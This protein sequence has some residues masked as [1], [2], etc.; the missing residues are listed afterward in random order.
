MWLSLDGRSERPTRASRR[1]TPQG[2][3]QSRR[4]RAHLV[5]GS[6]KAP[7]R[8][9]AMFLG[10]VPLPILSRLRSTPQSLW[11]PFSSQP[12]WCPRPDTALPSR[13]F[14]RHRP[15]P[16]I[17]PLHRHLHASVSADD[18]SAS[19]RSR[20]PER[21]RFAPSP[22]GHLHVGG[23]RTALFNW[24]FARH[25]GGKFI[26]RIEDTDVARSTV[27][28]EQAMLRDLHWLGLDWDEGPQLISSAADASGSR[29]DAA[30]STGEHGPY[31][32]SERG[33]L[34]QSAVKRLVDMGAAYPCFCTEEEL[35]RKR[36]EAEAAGRPP[37]YD[38]TWRDADP[39][40]V[41]QRMRDGCPY[42][43]RFRVPERAVIT[44]DD[45]VRGPV[46][47]DANATVGDFIIMRSTGV[48]VYNFCVAVDDALMGITT[49]IR[50]EEHLTNTLRQALI[51]DALGYAR[52]RYAHVSLILRPDGLS[53]RGDGQLPG[54]ARLERWHRARTVRGARAGG[55]VRAGARHQIGGGVRCDQTAVDERAAFASHVA[56]AI[57]RHA[58]AAVGAGRAGGGVAQRRRASRCHR[59][60]GG[61]DGS[62]SAAVA[63]VPGAHQRAVARLVGVG[64][65]QR[66]PAATA[67][68]VSAGGDTDQRRR[69]RAAHR[70]GRLLHGRARSAGG[71]RCA[72]A[73]DDDDEAAELHA[74]AWK[75]WVNALGKRLKRKGKKLFHP[76]RLAVTGRMS[77]PDVGSIVRMLYLADRGVAPSAVLMPQRMQ[78]LRQ[79][80]AASRQATATDAMTARSPQATS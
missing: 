32:Q 70:R 13:T 72:A 54:A 61:G 79:T 7:P 15:C 31:R 80:L 76:L 45:V 46:S 48:P 22:T 57:A 27:E 17:V 39:A 35:E 77:G 29:S 2:G 74:T 50:A 56:G 37:Q 28:S 34:Y 71:V 62:G 11:R 40:L 20:R 14:G 33:A 24:L 51:L 44:I 53:A 5:M 67:A 73:A 9:R 65:R 43:L 19:P 52:P 69:R 25:H 12:V 6:S 38:G 60:V 1:C 8:P 49:V 68:G 41:H 26:L 36:R 78:V 30:P 21:V 66:A 58:D 47:W 64:Q 16:I 23:A 3:P 18:T 59:S 63:G 75:T 42:T 10:R 4:Q 55:G